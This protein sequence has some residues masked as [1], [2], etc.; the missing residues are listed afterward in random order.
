MDFRD[1][2]AKETS[3]LIE[4]LLVSR[5]EAALEQFRTLRDALDQAARAAEEASVAAP[6][7]TDEI[8]EVVKR[9]NNAAGA[10]VRAVSQRVRDEARTAVDAVQAELEGQRAE[11]ERLA[12]ALAGAEAQV[13]VLREEVRIERDRL[14]STERELAAARDAHDA[15]ER[16]AREQ[17]DTARIE[18][19]LAL[20]QLTDARSAVEDELREARGLLETTL[21]EAARLAEQLEA[22]TTEKLTLQRDAASAQTAFE[23]A[24]ALRLETES[25]FRQES[26]ARSGV[27]RDLRDT[28][29]LLDAALAQSARLSHQLEAEGTEIA[30]LRA[31]LAET[32]VSIAELEDARAAAEARA[33]EAA[34]AQAALESELLDVRTTLDAA[35]AET[36]AVNA[37]LEAASSE[38]Q[39]LL[40]ELSAA[41]GEIATAQTQRDAVA[42]QLKH[43]AARVHTLERT[44]ARQEETMR[45]LESRLEHADASLRERAGDAEPDAAARSAEL[46]TL[47]DEIDRLGALM[48]TSVGAL[49]ALGGA[50]TLSDLLGELARQLATQFSRV[51]LFR[52]KGNRLEGEHQLGF[53]QAVDVT[54]LVIPLSVDSLLTRAATSGVVEAL[55]E[56]DREDGGVALFGSTPAAALALPIVLHEEPLAIAYVEHATQPGGESAQGPDAAST[57]FARLLVAHT[58]ALLTRLTNELKALAELREYATILLQEAEEMFLADFDAGRS[59]EELRSRLKDNIECARQL[60]AQRAA[61]EGSGASA[62]LDEQIASTID[63]QGSTRFAQELATLVGRPADRRAAEAS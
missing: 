36:S 6:P 5:S 46:T 45:Q 4:R 9:L 22:E 47:R 15:A 28:R 1:F 60:Y 51:A 48:S 37:Q 23:A 26:E 17:L 63:A 7:L 12:V 35:L 10:A 42:S 57:A 50:G 43:S 29:D 30:T 61:L 38:Q 54:K 19:E 53:D 31:E 40:A 49:D 44:Q 21:A 8:Q 52:L 34:H 33:G 58:V 56:S 41:Q 62:L 3:A 2:A 13:D 14:E 39:R 18:A 16:L 55:S 11:A 20:R 32:R 25:A 24:E 27:E 59:G